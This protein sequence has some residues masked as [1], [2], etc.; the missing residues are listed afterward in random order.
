MENII[1]AEKITNIEDTELTYER[2]KETFVE[3]IR[4][5]DVLVKNEQRIA[6]FFIDPLL[7]SFEAANQFYFSVFECDSIEKINTYRSGAG[8][9]QALTDAKQLIYYGLV[10]AVFIFGFD[11]LLTNKRKFGNDVI[12]ASMNIFEEKSIMQCYNELAHLQRKQFDLTIEEAMNIYDQLFANYCET[13]FDQGT[14]IERGRVLDDLHADLFKLTDCAN[15]NID[16]AG[17]VIVANEKAKNILQIRDE[18]N[19]KVTGVYYSMIEGNPEKIESIARFTHLKKALLESEKQANIHI[20][21]QFK[22]K[23]LLLEVYTCYPPIPIA[24][25]FESGIVK[26]MEEL[27]QI[28]ANYEITVTGGMNLARAPW[29]NPALNGLVEMYDQLKKSDATYG[30]VHGNGGIGEVQGVAILERM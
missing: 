30:V 16:F 11:P 4:I 15:P 6:Y 5:H 13:Y 24:F 19:V 26:D 9:I 23:N 17:G 27:L 1:Y 7:N 14:I 2:L 8:P 28:F 29:N 22:R 3:A 21:E 10:D 25:L 18:D 20:A 12:K